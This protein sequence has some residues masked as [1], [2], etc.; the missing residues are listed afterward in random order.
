[1]CLLSPLHKFL[2]YCGF[3]NIHILQFIKKDIR[4]TILYPLSP[5]PPSC[6]HER[7]GTIIA[8][9]STS[10]RSPCW[11]WDWDWVSLMPEKRVLTI[12]LSTLQNGET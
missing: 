1:M 9:I 5:F 3:L 11:D 4:D 12:G 2:L 7:I 10:I 8:A 6:E